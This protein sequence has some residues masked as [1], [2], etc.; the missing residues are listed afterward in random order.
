MFYRQFW[1]DQLIPPYVYLNLPQNS[2]V[3]LIATLNICCDGRISQNLVA[4]KLRRQQMQPH[5]THHFSYHGVTS[6]TVC[7]DPHL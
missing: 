2:F 4:D 7:S 5:I 1:F 3:D 6:F